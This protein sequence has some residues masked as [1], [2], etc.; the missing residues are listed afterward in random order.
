[1]SRLTA[2]MRLPDF[3]FQTSNGA[4]KCVETDVL[5]KRTVFWVIRYIGC[6]ICR[7]DIHVLAQKYSRLQ[8]KGV[9]LF[10]VLQSDPKNV[11]EE[12]KDADIP[13]D[14][15]CDPEMHIYKQFEIPTAADMKQLGGTTPE[16]LQRLQNKGK[17][18][19][20]CGFSHGKYEGDEMQ[21]PAVWVVEA[22]GTLSYIKYGEA[23]ADI[24]TPDELI[25]ML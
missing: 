23:V 12:L 10:V 11:Q 21:L 25:A 2:G 4:L 6:T 8:E 16:L 13:F 19:A 5:G 14:I 20:A 7:Y 3:S 1:M 17:A 22:D 24:P 18:A 9:Q 15:I